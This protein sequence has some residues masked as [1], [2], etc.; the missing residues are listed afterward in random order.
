MVTAGSPLGLD[1]VYKKLLIHGPTRPSRVGQ[2]LNTWYAGDPIAIGCP[3]R[4]SWGP[5]LVELHVENPKARAHDIAEYLAH[6]EVARSIHRGL[7][8]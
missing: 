2:W 6:P 7:R 4:R 5:D 1:A 8:D 3:L